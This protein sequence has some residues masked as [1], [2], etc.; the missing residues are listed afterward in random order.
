MTSPAVL[1]LAAPLLVLCALLAAACGGGGKDP[2]ASLPTSEPQLDIA[3]SSTPPPLM[4]ATPT[5]PPVTPSPTPVP[6]SPTPPP[7]TATPVPPTPIPVVATP[8]PIAAT[9]IPPPPPPLPATPVPNPST[10]TTSPGPATTDGLVS[11]KPASIDQGGFAV[12]YL[13]TDASAATLRFGGKNYPMLK[14]G[15]RWWA[16]VG[17]GAL[18]NPGMAPVTI[19]YTTPAGAQQT[20]NSSVAIVH[21]DYPTEN[22]DLDASSTALLAPDI[23]NAELAQRAGIYDVYTMQRLWSGAFVRPNAAGLSDLYGIMRSYNHGPVTSYHTGT[24]FAA[25]D[26]TQAIAAAA[27]KVAFAGQMQVR[28]NS[29]IIDHGA[30]VFTAYH[31]LSRID[32]TTGQNITAGQQVGLTGHTGLVDGPHLHWE[33]IIRGIEVD[34][35]LWLKGTEIGP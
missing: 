20:A 14:S 30:G 9:P 23:V 12:V 2:L 4:T 22:I 25:F 5:P 18:S 17:V 31:H 10:G 11:F 21:H 7:P 6:P 35:L 29:V 13:N 33:V 32:V 19:A 3:P 27:G 1:R 26:G 16:I 15:T 24:D 34:G 28:G 8:L